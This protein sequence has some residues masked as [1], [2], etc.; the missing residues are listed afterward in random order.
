MASFF[1]GF[2]F[3]LKYYLLKNVFTIFLKEHGT[4]I[5]VS[6]TWKKS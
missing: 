1:S 4:I 5:S 6:V 3:V 2:K